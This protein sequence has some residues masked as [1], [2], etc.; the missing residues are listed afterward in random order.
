MPLKYGDVVVKVQKLRGK[1]G[2]VTISRVNAIVLSSSVKTALGAD[3]KPLTDADGKKLEPVEHIDL[4]FPDPGLQQPLKTRAMDLI[5]RPAYDVA[6]WT[7]DAWIGY[8]VPV[9]E[10]PVIEPAG[11]A[12]AAEQDADDSGG[13]A[14]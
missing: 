11:E 2:A 9:T 7:E 8:E 12:V 6:P 10:I 5:F 1:D 3:R 4:A 14:D 13:T